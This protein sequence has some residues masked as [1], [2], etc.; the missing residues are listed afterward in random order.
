MSKSVILESKFSYFKQMQFVFQTSSVCN[1]HVTFGILSLKLH[2]YSSSK[3][4]LKLEYT[5]SEG[6]VPSVDN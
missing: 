1:L 4:A 5:N 2:N 3:Y 6:A